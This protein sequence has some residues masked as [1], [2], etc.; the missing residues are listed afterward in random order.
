LVVDKDNKATYREI[1]L[2]AMA[3]KLRIVTS[4]LKA[5]ERIIV[6]GL[7]RVRPGDVVAPQI[8]EMNASQTAQAQAQ[9]G[10]SKVAQQ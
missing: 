2:G 7:Q 4:G 6:N 8:V 3:D 10:S 9:H 1:K 5:G